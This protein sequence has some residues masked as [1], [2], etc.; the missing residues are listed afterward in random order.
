[1]TVEDI[2]KTID[3]CSDMGHEISEKDI[4]FFIL[5]REYQNAELAYRIIFDDPTD[6]DCKEYENLEDIKYLRDYMN[7]NFVGKKN[8]PKKKKSIEDFSDITFE[9]NKDALIGLLKEVEDAKA[10]GTLPLKDALKAEI[11]IRTKLNDKF[12]V[13]EDAN[14]QQIVVTKKFD[15]ICPYLHKECWLQTKEDAMKRYNLIENPQSKE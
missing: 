4:S 12:N 14:E 9:E 7:A 2:D 10:D 1:M 13:S 15:Y 6:M 11:D 5:K 8:Q 3:E